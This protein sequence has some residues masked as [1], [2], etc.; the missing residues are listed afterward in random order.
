MLLD[1]SGI[2][3]FDTTNWTDEVVNA[4]LGGELYTSTI[5]TSLKN[6]ASHHDRSVTCHVSA[7]QKD[8]DI[9]RHHLCGHQNHH[10]SDERDSGDACLRG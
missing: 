3:V 7:I 9:S 4:I 2:I 8:T 5:L 10:Y 6:P 1:L